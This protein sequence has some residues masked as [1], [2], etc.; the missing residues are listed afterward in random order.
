MQSLAAIPGLVA[1][2]RVGVDGMSGLRACC[3]R[4]RPRRSWSADLLARRTKT[5]DD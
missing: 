1:A 2:R 4:P 3:P 5:A